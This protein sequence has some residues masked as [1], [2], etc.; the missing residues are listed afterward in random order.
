MDPGSLAIRCPACPNP[1]VNLPK[2][3]ASVPPNETYLYRKFISVDACF[4]L[5]RRNVSSEERDPGLFS[6]KAYFVPPGPYGEWVASLPEQN[7]TSTC[8]GLAAMDQAETKY[9]KGYASTGMLFCLCSRHKLV[10]P[11]GAGDLTKGEKHGCG[12]YMV[13]YSQ[14]ETGSQLERV[15]IYD[16]ACQWFKNFF[17]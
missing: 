6:G 14:K 3:L 16:I 4:W 2:D 17:S 7:D 11:K 9:S 8:P 15:V 5:K 13:M 12:D 1:G 10:Q